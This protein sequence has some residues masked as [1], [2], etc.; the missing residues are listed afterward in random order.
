MKVNQSEI[1]NIEEIG[2]L[3]GN[4]VKLVKT[5]G[6]LFFAVARQFGQP[7]ESGL[8]LGSHAGIVKYQL[9]KQYPNFQPSLQKSSV[10]TDLSVIDQHSHFLS[11]DL[12]K[13]GHDIYSVENGDKVEFHVLK[14]GRKIAQANGMLIGTDLHIIYTNAS[15]SMAKSLS[16]AFTEKALTKKLKSVKFGDKK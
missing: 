9:S 16:G 4:P 13:S 5:K 7:Q 12:R 15:S 6:G 14:H 11:D 3:D 2:T 1:A 10:F 8:A